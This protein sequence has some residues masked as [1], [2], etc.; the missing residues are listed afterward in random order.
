LITRGA[1]IFSNDE[2]DTKSAA[3]FLIVLLNCIE[4]W[5]KLYKKDRNQETEFA[6]VYNSMKAKGYCF[7][8]E[9]KRHKQ[10]MDA[11]AAQKQQ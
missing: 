6:K 11:Q 3:A 1:N 7:P 9:A 5:G 10:E 8:S 2:K 4:T